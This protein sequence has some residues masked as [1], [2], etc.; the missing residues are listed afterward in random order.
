MIKVVI[1]KTSD[2][3]WHLQSYLIDTDQVLMLLSFSRYIYAEMAAQALS[4][5]V[6]RE[7]LT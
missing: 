5:H 3:L 7:D 1:F 4:L 2:G 6:D